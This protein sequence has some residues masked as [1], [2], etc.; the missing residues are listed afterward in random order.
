MMY[1]EMYERTRLGSQYR[2]DIWLLTDRKLN[3][4][5]EFTDRYLNYVWEFTDRYLVSVEAVN[6][7]RRTQTLSTALSVK[8]I[9]RKSQLAFGSNSEFPENNTEISALSVSMH[10]SEFACPT[11]TSSCPVQSL[12]PHTGDTFNRK[13]SKGE[14]VKNVLITAASRKIFFNVRK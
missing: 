5:W 7:L 3:Y 10:S 1:K 6:R 2:N 13:F 11:D 4:I 12:P 8:F 9:L 14:N